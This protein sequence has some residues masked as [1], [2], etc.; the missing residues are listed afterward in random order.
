M[1]RVIGKC[2]KLSPLVGFFQLELGEL[3]RIFHV[4]GSART[5]AIASRSAEKLRPKR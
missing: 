2:H 4:I 3:N 5:S 1:G